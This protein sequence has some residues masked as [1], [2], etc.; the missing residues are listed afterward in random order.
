MQQLR[1]RNGGGPSQNATRIPL[2]LQAVF[3]NGNRGIVVN[4]PP[5][6]KAASKTFRT[7]WGR[8]KLLPGSGS[9]EK[10]TIKSVDVEFPLP[11]RSTTAKP[12]KKK[13]STFRCI[14]KEIYT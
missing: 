11:K 5:P 12:K 6:E 2:A 7:W 9:T 8:R 1:T 10:S 4:T 3:L 13:V 14:H